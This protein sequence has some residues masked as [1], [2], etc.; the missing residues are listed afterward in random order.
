MMPAR[1][2]LLVLLLHGTALALDADPAAKRVVEVLGAS[3]DRAALPRVVDAL[4]RGR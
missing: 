2:A 4:A 1:I 3:G